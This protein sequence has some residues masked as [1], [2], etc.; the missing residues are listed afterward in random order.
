ML[1]VNDD[2]VASDV[3]DHE[4][5]IIN[6][7]NGMYFTMDKVGAELWQLLATP[8]SLPAVAAILA[9]RYGLA[10][11]EVVRDLEE[12]VEDLLREQLIVAAHDGRATTSDERAAAEP[13]SQPSYSKPVLMKYTDMSEVLALDPPLPVLGADPRGKT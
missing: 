5:V 6:L 11:T 8:R 13:A 12:V 7:S 10:E 3:V 1:T 2:L 4:A 9:G